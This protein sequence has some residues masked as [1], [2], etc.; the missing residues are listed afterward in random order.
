M[1][2]ALMSCLFVLTIF[3]APAARANDAVTIETPYA[4]AAPSGARSA[5]AF[6]TLHYPA[7]VDMEA[8]AIPDRL[9]HVQ[10]PVAGRA[11]I[12]TLLI[13]DN[14][15]MMRKVSAL[16]LPPSGRLEFSPQGAHIMMMELRQPL[17][18]GDSFPMTLI[19]EKAGPVEVAVPVRAPGDMPK[20]ASEMTRET[21]GGANTAVAEPPE[22]KDVHDELEE[23]LEREHH[24]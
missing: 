5:A 23:T 16:P 7:A 8:G 4:F 24:H 11:E 9:M 1:K 12:H 10:T 13:D 2:Y 19:F 21:A 17:K 6:M 14:A 22:E 15:M 18:A 3:A 20:I